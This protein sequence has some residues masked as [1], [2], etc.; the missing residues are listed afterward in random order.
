[1]S[2]ISLL[3]PV[4]ACGVALAGPVSGARAGL[5]PVSVTVNPEA[6]K[7]RWTYAIVLPTDAMIRAGDYFTIYDFAG[8]VAGSESQPTDWAFSVA[9][10]GGVPPGVDPKDDPGQDN[11]SWAY[12][13]PTIPSGQIG[14]GNFW[15]V[16]DFGTATESVFTA[17]THR[18]SD[19]LVDTNITPTTVPVPT[20]SPPPGVAE[21]ATLVLAGLGLPLVGLVR[22]RRRK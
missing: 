4:L 21:P 9:K 1:M 10:S 18:T 3:A 2:R 14:L 20:A 12:T 13:G 11:L 15:A 22:R 17:R 16:S 19:G 7:F 5:L 6:D 8:L